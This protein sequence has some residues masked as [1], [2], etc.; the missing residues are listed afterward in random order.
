MGI[1]RKETFVC[2]DC[3]S[4]GLDPETDHI[5]EV[6][7]VHFTFD[8]II[9][10]Y[11]TLVDPGVPIPAESMAIHHITEE[12]VEG[13]PKIKTILPELI[14]FIG[15]ATVVG[16]GVLF[17]LQLIAN[18]AKRHDIPCNLAN[19][20]FFDTLRLARYYGRSPIN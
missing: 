1:L 4:T 6:A 13:K 15:S 11:E 16:H 3:E 17:D 12:M 18:A 9:D 20:N 19:Q 8:E 5:I 14:D 10:R 2:V 7:A